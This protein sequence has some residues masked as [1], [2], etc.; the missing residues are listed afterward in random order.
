MK[1]WQ[2]S[3]LR[4][5]SGLAILAVWQITAQLQIVPPFLL[6]PFSDVVVRLFEDLVS[7]ALP[8]AIGGTLIRT[9]TG[10]GIA[11]VLG[12]AIGVMIARM[13]WVKWFFDPLIS[14]GLP[15]PK[16]AFLPVFILWFGVY[17][18][19]K[20]LM[21]AFSA[22]F[23][24]IVSAW[25][26]TEHLD[27]AMLWSA[28]SLGATPRRLLWQVAMPAAV[29]QIFTGLQVALPTALIVDVVAEMAMGGGG[30][31][32]AMMLTM[33]FM[34]SVGVFSG[35][36]ALAAVGMVLVKAME[37]IRARLLVWHPEAD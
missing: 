1:P 7:G 19:S 36:L 20:I 9:L 33:R 27:K 16:I 14:I 5:G 34:D 37:V 25:A 12:V 30:I 8:I 35:I 24:V 28:Q 6:P 17:D 15:L 21:I 4:W 22:I 10:F 3:A 18:Q 26:G 13:P 29:P 11:A 31:G 23:P 32:G 2:R